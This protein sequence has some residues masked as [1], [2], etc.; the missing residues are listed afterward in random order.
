M[1]DIILVGYGGH[2]KSVADCIERQ[3]KYHIIGYTE[4]KEVASKY[5]YLGTDEILKKYYN[6]GVK[7]AVICLGY[8]GKGKIR[9]CIY[10]MVKNIGF[11]LPVIIDPSSIISKT[12][13]IGE[14]TFVGKGA[15]INTDAMIG[16]MCIVNTKALIEHDCLIDEF[17]HIAV[18]ATICG[19]VSIGKRCFVGANATII[20]CMKVENNAIIP[21]GVVV[22][23][24][25][26][27]E[28][29]KKLGG[30]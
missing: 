30:G 25:N 20:Q 11:N 14:G 21:A 23:R 28:I 6:Q 5:P 4:P 29:N 12:A 7:N 2:A 19:Q 10:E 1:E 26:M 16:K 9:E 8:L 3:K 18:G 24:K 27:A 22:R 15:I 17:T 13:T